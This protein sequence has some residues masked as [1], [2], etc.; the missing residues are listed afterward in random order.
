MI[1]ECS[2][3]KNLPKTGV[4]VAVVGPCSAGKSTLL[5]ALKAAGYNARSPAQEHTIVPDLWQR[6][7][8]PDILIYLDVSYDAARERRPH[9]DGGPQRLA[10]QHGKL[11]HA[12]EHND[13]YLDTSN[14][15]PQEVREAVFDFLDS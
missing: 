3:R 9:I 4:R 6:N 5:P 11:A 2:A 1:T 12:L 7:F 15:T 13:F 10:D 14:L 8:Q